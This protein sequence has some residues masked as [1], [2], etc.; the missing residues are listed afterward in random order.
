M[1]LLQRLSIIFWVVIVGFGCSLE[2]PKV[3]FLYWS[4]EGNDP[5]YEQYPLEEGEY[6]TSILPGFYPDPSIVR[7]EDDYYMVHST[8]AYFPG[9]PIFHSKDLVNWEQIGN[10]IHRPSQFNPDSIGISRGVFA[11]TIE[12]HDGVFYV[13]NT[14]VDAGGNYMVTATNPAGPWSDP[15]FLDRVGGI[16]PSI[17]FDDDGK[18]YI[19]NNDAPEGEPEYP[20]HRAVWIREYDIVN[21]RSISESKVLIN[22][23][24]DFST[25]PIWI[26]GPH[27]M[28]ID[29]QYYL[30]S[31]EGGTSVNHSQVVLKGSHP[32]GPFTPFPGNPILTQRDIPVDREFP[33]EYTGHAD[34]VET[35]FGEWW[36]I[37]L[38]VRPYDGRNFNTGRETFLLPVAWEDGWPIILKPGQEVPLKLKKPNLD[39]YRTENS[40]ASGNFGY[41]EEFDDELGLDWLFVRVPKEKW[42][43]LSNGRLSVTPR[44]DSISGLGQPSYVAKRQQHAYAQFQTEMHYTPEHVGDEAGMV[45]F[46]NRDHYIFFGLHKT[47]EPSQKLILRAVRGGEVQSY[48]A[49]EYSAQ[50]IEL[51][52]EAEGGRYSFY[53]RSDHNQDWL[54]LEGQVDATL[55]S[56]E[57]A[58]GFVGAVVGPYAYASPRP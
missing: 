54:L 20:G 38:G 52:M 47:S 24:V 29:G 53:Y 18:V 10:V 12:Y 51:K 45:A 21:N 44:S 22:G 40:L 6:Y 46:Q 28:K 4:Y 1:K 36:A 13:L 57:V 32:L 55:L 16:D 41:I 5:I 25:K 31:A 34:M 42:Y 26:E 15:I 9:I 30:H 19:L 35:K 56:T 50:E 2:V 37:F 48:S 7:V 8:F 33:V 43:Q 17:F 14:F 39:E 23:G 11:P 27:M 58:G 3:E 49:I